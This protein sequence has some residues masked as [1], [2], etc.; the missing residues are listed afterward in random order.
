[1][2][3]CVC[4]GRRGAGGAASSGVGADGAGARSGGLIHTQA[5]Q[6]AGVTQA[7]RACL[8]DPLPKHLPFA[9]APRQ[10]TIGAWS[11][12]PGSTG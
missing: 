12:P 7:G 9:D 1:M 6:G 4:E 11:P 8:S 2:F 10:S 5:K 3:V